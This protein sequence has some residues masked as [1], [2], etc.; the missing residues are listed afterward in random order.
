MHVHIL[1]FLCIN[2]SIDNRTVEIA[3]E[4]QIINEKNP[5]H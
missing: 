1:F 5:K 2:K 4:K 3:I